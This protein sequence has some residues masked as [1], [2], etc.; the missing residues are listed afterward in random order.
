MF[1]A[2]ALPESGDVGVEVYNVND[3]KLATPITGWHSTGAH[4]ES[5]SAQG[6][7]SGVYFLRLT[8]NA[9]QVVHKIT[10]VRQSQTRAN[11][12]KGSSLCRHLLSGVQSMIEFD[13]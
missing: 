2:F 13:C 11:D 10:V 1:L 5:W 12:E 6:L 8:F 3:Q 4:A 7:L 9:E